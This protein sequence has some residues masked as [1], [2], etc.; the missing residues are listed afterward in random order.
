MLK[1][2]FAKLPD[3]RVDNIV[4]AFE[5]PSVGISITGDVGSANAYYIP[6]VNPT[7]PLQTAFQGSMNWM[8]WAGIADADTKIAYRDL[9][10]VTTLYARIL[11]SDF[12]IKVPS[13]NTPQVWKFMFV[14]QTVLVYAERQT[15][16]H[17]YIPILFGVPAEDGLNYQTKSLAENVSPIQDITS[18][19][20]NADIASRRR[21]ISDRVLYDPS[22]ITEAHINNS[23]P[24]AKIPVRPAAFGKNVADA[25]YAFP[26]RDDQAVVNAQKIQMYGAMANMI[27]GQNPVRQ[28]QFVKGNKTQSEFQDVMQ[29]AN[30]RDQLTA[31]GYE[32]QVFTPMKEILKI[33]TLQY[34]AG[35]SLYSR[36]TE[37]DINVDPVAL[38]KA[39]LNFKM[40]DGLTPTDKLMSNEVSIT[41]MQAVASSP[42]LSAAYNIGPMFS[43]LMKIKGA[44]I[45]DFEKSPQQIEYETATMQ[46]QQMVFQLFKENPDIKRE[47]LPPVPLPK[48]YGYDPT[49]E[50]GVDVSKAASQ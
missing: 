46:Y 31:I 44:N 36:D 28:G 30:G 29:N 22:R 27:S 1:D 35:T 48:D 26:F 2:L 6:Q 39:V 40:S 4:A 17:G 45:S 49:Q 20:S 32:T 50:S 38:R 8:A 11:P 25:V 41:A 3:A 47:Q 16:A 37:K 14:N 10:Q 18:A 13:P 43:Y 21:A 33:N 7:A 19:I 5:S 12:G 9:Y 42:Q 23:N 15:N 24:S 34:Q